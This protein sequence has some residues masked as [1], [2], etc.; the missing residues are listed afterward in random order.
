MRYLI[1]LSLIL[2]SCGP[3]Y[4][5][6]RAKI[7]LKKAEQHGANISNDTTYAKVK[8]KAIGI[9]VQFEPKIITE[10]GHPMIFTKDS[11][12]TRILIKKG[13]GDIDTV[14]AET[15]CP[16]RVV[17]KKVPVSNNQNIE[18]KSNLPWWVWVVFGLCAL[19]IT[20]LCF[21]R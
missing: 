5:L 16:D 11:V 6:K 3:N 17:E 18:A 13:P 21:K 15:K 1:I 14:Y 7:N 8:F 20:V 19:V 4:Y 12:I 10:R 9:K 2:F